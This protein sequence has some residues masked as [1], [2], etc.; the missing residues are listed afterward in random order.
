MTQAGIARD[1]ILTCKTQGLLGSIFRRARQMKAE[2]IAFLPLQLGDPA[3]FDF[4]PLSSFK[5]GVVRAL[6]KPSSYAYGDPQGYPP[7]REKIAEIEG[8]SAADVFLGNGVSDMMDK[9]LNV[10]AVRGTNILFPAPVFPPYLDLNRKNSIESRL[11]RCD[12]KTWQPDI[13]SIEAGID[14]ATSMVLINSPNNPTGAVYHQ[15]ALT[16]VIDLAE[17]VNRERSIRG[18]VPLCLVFDS[19]YSEHYYGERPTD[20][21]KILRDR[22]ITWVI[23]NGASKSL[24]VPGLRVGYAV[25]GGSDRESL[26]DGLYNECILPLCMNSVFQ[27]GYLAALEDPGLE[28][29]F[30]T[31]R[32][33]LRRRRDVLLHGFSKIPA[34]HAV[35]PEGA[36]YIIVE[37]QT[38]FSDDLELGLALLQEQKICTSRMSAFFDHETLPDQTSLRLTFLPPEDVLED[39]VDRFA[40]FMERHGTN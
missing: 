5:E 3:Q 34:I 17:R 29:Y 12:P 37:M 11:Y 25:L 1:E 10:T 27:E 30:Q 20:V 18:Q 40:R 22:D 9:I 26:H 16:A 14:D 19:I 21:K 2:G 28:D 4:P 39:A 31:N 36:F 6:E 38:R 35:R 33:R 8:V 7:L 13:A 24:N 32:D 23:F 15:E